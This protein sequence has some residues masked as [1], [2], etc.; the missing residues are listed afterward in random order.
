MLVCCVNNINK[1][2]EVEVR[3]ER[4]RAA[5]PASTSLAL[6]IDWPPLR[7]Q[8]NCQVQV[9]FLQSDRS[10]IKLKQRCAIYSSTLRTDS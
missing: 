5:L 2:G 4:G 10:L 8:V 9:E 6:L 1:A 3:G 7:Q